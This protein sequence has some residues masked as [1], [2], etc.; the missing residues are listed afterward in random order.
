MKKVSAFLLAILI[1][2]VM[3]TGCGKD[4]AA[5][6]TVDITTEPTAVDTTREEAATETAVLNDEQILALPA[7]E[8]LKYWSGME[9]EGLSERDAEEKKNEVKARQ[10][11][12]YIKAKRINDIAY[13][14]GAGDKVTKEACKVFNEIDVDSYEIEQLTSTDFFVALHISKSSSALFPL[15][16]SRWRLNTEND[17]ATDISVFKRINSIDTNLNAYPFKGVVYFSYRISADLGC[18]ETMDDFNKLVEKYKTDNGVSSEFG[19]YLVNFLIDNHYGD[20]SFAKQPIKRTDMESWAKTTLGITSFDFRK[21]YMYNSEYDT[22]GTTGYGRPFPP[23]TLS[24]SA[25][26]QTTRI[27]TI[28]LDYYLD[29]VYLFKAKTMRYTVRENADGTLTLLSTKLLYDSGYDEWWAI[30]G[31]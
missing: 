4:T 12:N 8:F 27:Y 11:L 21:H 3:L 25:Y 15:G 23:A 16:T 17:G 30:T 9:F 14:I 10:F 1:F 19:D 5:D 7:I 22:I 24:S 28:V 29:G 2:A 31:I 6:T 20:A 26:D 13:F 18:F